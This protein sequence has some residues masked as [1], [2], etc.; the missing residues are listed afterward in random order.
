MALCGPGSPAGIAGALVAESPL[1]ASPHA[2]VLC[3]AAFQ[4]GIWI[5]AIAYM[6]CYV[7]VG[8]I[9][10]LVVGAQDVCLLSALDFLD[11]PFLY[12]IAYRLLPSSASPPPE[13]VPSKAITP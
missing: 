11:A 10:L 1:G 7:H 8:V 13:M 6:G 3:C 9:Q 5:H 12:N 4:P 2:L